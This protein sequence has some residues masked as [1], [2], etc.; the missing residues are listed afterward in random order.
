[1]SVD[2]EAARKAFSRGFAYGGNN[3]AQIQAFEEQE[4]RQQILADREADREYQ[5][6]RDDINYE[7]RMQ[8]LLDAQKREDAQREEER[9][10]DRAVAM[11]AEGRESPQLPEGY[12][13]ELFSPQDPTAT[14]QRSL[15]PY[16]DPNIQ[17][18]IKGKMGLE[19]E[20]EALGRKRVAE[21]L[22]PFEL[23]QIRAREG[24]ARGKRPDEMSAEEFQAYLL[25]EEAES[26][27][28]Q[29][30]S[31]L[32]IADAFGSGGGRP[33]AP[34]DAQADF[35]RQLQRAGVDPARATDIMARMSSPDPEARAQA[36]MEFVQAI[37]EPPPTT[38]GAPLSGLLGGP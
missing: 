6:S 15:E 3:P 9:L 20:G 26:R 14:M 5:T 23:A 18:L 2:W 8:E 28:R 29:K 11:A 35:A 32:G 36:M 4:R 7:R 27:A 13:P 17:A 1:M 12:S 22:Q 37:M 24:A 30:G 31:G 33:T 38:G 25:R 10:W 21:E 19:A 16:G 34:T